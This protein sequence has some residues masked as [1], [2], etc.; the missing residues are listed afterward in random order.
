MENIAIITPVEDIKSE[1]VLSDIR[2]LTGDDSKSVIRA[3][4]PG[5]YFQ[6]YYHG[7]TIEV[8]DYE[9]GQVRSVRD[10][11]SDDIP[12]F[13]IGV[14]YGLTFNP[15]TTES[16][17]TNGNVYILNQSSFYRNYP[18]VVK[19]TI[20]AMSGIRFAI[21]YFTIN[22][23][24]VYM[25]LI[26]DMKDGSAADKYSMSFGYVVDKRDI[27]KS[28]LPKTAS[29]LADANRKLNQDEIDRL[30]SMLLDEMER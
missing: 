5:K 14:S 15:V 29:E 18:Q 13:N 6:Y 9:D 21:L 19:D 3:K 2:F 17:A 25:Q 11:K 12:Q 27:L 16:L 1:E 7:A 24:V 22:G 30:V 23:A 10:I 26:D 4:I 20:D 28:M 8:V